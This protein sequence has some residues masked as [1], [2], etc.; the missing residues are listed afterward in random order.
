MNDNKNIRDVNQINNQDE[1]QNIILK[2][3]YFK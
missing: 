3:M 2:T 1:T